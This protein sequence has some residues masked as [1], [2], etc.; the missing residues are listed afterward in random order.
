MKASEIIGNR[1]LPIV[2]II[3]VITVVI[4][5]IIAIGIGRGYRGSLTAVS[6]PKKA[7]DATLGKKKNIKR[8]MIKKSE[9]EEC[10]EVTPDGVVRVYATCGGELISSQ[11]PADPKY[12]LDLMRLAA[13]TDPSK[14]PTDQTG[15]YYDITIETDSGSQT[16]RV[17][18]SG[19]GGSEIINTINNVINT[20]TNPSPTPGS[21]PVLDATPFST[22]IPVSTPVPTPEPGAS[23]EIGEEKPFTCNFNPD[24]TAKKPYR[25]SNVVCTDTPQTP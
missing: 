17:Y 3:F 11:R 22:P 10:I 4:V 19:G 1:L 25:V 23:P 9:G 5:S 7:D 24:G 13:E 18:T 8:I 2:G 6:A 20:L 14:L 15:A 16:V 12:I 21:S